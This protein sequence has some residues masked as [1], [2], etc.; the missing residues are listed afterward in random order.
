[1]DTNDP[2]Q[3]EVSLAEFEAKLPQGDI[4]LF[5]ERLDN[6]YDLDTDLVYNQWKELKEND[7]GAKNIKFYHNNV[8]MVLIPN[9]VVQQPPNNDSPT[10][11]ILTTGTST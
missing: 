2:F 7:Q 9:T 5:N 11:S 4:N 8:I 6:G 1:M 3:S 10:E